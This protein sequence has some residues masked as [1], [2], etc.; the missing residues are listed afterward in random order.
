MV[1]ME[2]EVPNSSRIH[3]KDT[4]CQDISDNS[5]D[6]DLENCMTDRTQL[7]YDKRDLPD[8]STS[9]FLISTL[10][11]L[12]IAG[13]GSIFSGWLINWAQ[14]KEF[15]KEIPDALMLV[16]PLLGLKGNL[17]MTFASKLGTLSNTGEID[18]CLMVRRLIKRYI[19]FLQ[20]QS[21]L[22]SLLLAVLCVV[23]AAAFDEKGKLSTQSALIIIASAIATASISSFIIEM[24]LIA[25]VFTLSHF[26]GIDSDNFA[27][28]VAASCGDFGTFL[29]FMGFGTLQ[30]KSDQGD[31]LW[32][33]VTIL[34]FFVLYILPMMVYMNYK[35]KQW[36]S[37]WWAIIVAM[38]LSGAGGWILKYAVNTLKWTTFSTFQPLIAGLAGNRI[39]V[40]SS[41]ISTSLVRSRA[42]IGTIPYGTLR[43]K[44]NP[45]STFC[46]L[47]VHTKMS[48]LLVMTTIPAQLLF[49]FITIWL[50]SEIDYNNSLVWF[51]L[52][53]LAAGLIQMIV[54]L[55]FCQCI[56]YLLWRIGCDPDSSAIPLL[57]SF[58]DLI[59][60]VLLLGVYLIAKP[61]TTNH[62][63]CL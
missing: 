52:S 61:V 57:T 21:I 33:T 58:S 19:P 11:S 9:S 6:G 56:V 46:G 5:Q 8:D 20:V 24:F 35:S 15:L 17:E 41:R 28:P 59:G 53:Y 38:V 3:G 14:N 36:N 60:S 25:L 62:D 4:I 27:T 2:N 13:L 18:D 49:L 22:F 54:L 50:N 1:T 40:Q 30:L 16:T 34:L 51:I 23:V 37:G 39:S 45:C 12:L 47:G 26:F 43:E 29:L 10:A 31:D 48:R 42:P 7:S 44:F 55:Y 32:P 63:N